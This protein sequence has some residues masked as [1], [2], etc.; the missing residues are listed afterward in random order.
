MLVECELSKIIIN[1]VREHQ[2]VVLRELAEPHREFPIVI[3]I[4]EAVAIDRKL[5]DV[6][7]PRPLTHDLLISVMEEMGGRLE[8]II[9]N[10]LKDS[11]FYAQLEVHRND[12][13]ILVDSR[14]SDAI[15]LSVRSGCRVF[16]DDSV[17]KKVMMSMA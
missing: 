10:D 7:I 15:A 11:T 5:K 3:G 9:I 17:L 12:E 2:I 16:V 1:E 6:P 8:R 14:P 4:F 13:T